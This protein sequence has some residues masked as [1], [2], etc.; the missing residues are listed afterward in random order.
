MTS[1]TRS[2]W[3]LLVSARDPGAAVGIAEIVEA[4]RGDGR[5]ELHVVAGEPG[6]GHLE[7]RGIAVRRVGG[8]GDPASLVRLRS[9][10]NE[11]LGRI[12]P[13]ALLVGL[14]GPDVGIDEV[15]LEVSGA[16][17]TYAL[18]DYWGDVNDG[19]GV[20]ART[21]LVMDEEAARLTKARADVRTAV[22]GSVKHASFAEIDVPSTRRYGRRR[23]GV[24]DKDV[25]AAFYGQPLWDD[26]GYAATLSAVRGLRF[27]GLRLM[28]RP[29]PKEDRREVE[30]QLHSLW[31]PPGSWGMD[32]SPDV[33]TSLCAADLALS[34]YSTCLV[35]LLFLIRAATEP[36]AVPIFLLFDDALMARYRAHARLDGV[37]PAEQDLALLVLDVDQLP[38]MVARALETGTRAEV[39]RRAR[40]A[41]PDPSRAAIRVLDQIAE[42]LGNLR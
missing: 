17:P 14:S 25:V 3:R 13:N 5:F 12:E 2:P 10:A 24:S 6:A 22:V 9:E 36:F 37:P 32:L 16:L 8:A 21:Y 26:P 15:L 7:D 35:D 19:L 1:S 27:D 28:Y 29:H 33:A 41:T 31:G 30:E 4:A 20:P 34:A 18:Q 23:L 40:S 11:L 39:W 42:D 38:T